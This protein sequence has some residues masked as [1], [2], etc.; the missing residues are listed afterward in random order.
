MPSFFALMIGCLKVWLAV[1]PM[2]NVRIVSCVPGS[3]ID[4]AAMMPTAS[5]SFTELAG[6]QVAA[7]AMRADAA[8]AFAGQHR[9][10]LELL[11][12][13][14]FD[15]GRDWLVDHL[16]RLD[17]LLLRST[18][19]TIVSQLTRPMMR[20]AEIDDFFVAFVDRPEPRCR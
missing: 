12:A 16:V 11:D 20:V 3:P 18:G 1:P 6:R 15:L 8:L 13:D 4:C 19:S 10:N 2:W 17:D 7:V 14:L 9:A 5:P